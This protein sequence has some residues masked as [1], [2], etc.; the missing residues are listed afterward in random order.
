LLLARGG[1]KGAMDT[2]VL[3]QLGRDPRALAAVSGLMGVFALVPGMPF[4][5]FMAGAVGLGYLAMRIRHAPKDDTT[6]DPDTDE[7]PAPRSMGDTLDLD[8]MHVEFAA[9][10]V[11][12]VLDPATGLEARI[13]N[14][15]THIAEKFG[16][17]M[18][19]I[20]LTDNAALEAGTYI[21]RI[22]GVEAGHGVLRP[23]MMLALLPDS[24]DD[25]P[26]GTDVEE[27]VYGAPARWIRNRDQEKA[28]LRGATTI[29]PTEVLATHLLEITKRN[30]QRLLTLKALRRIL[31]EMTLLSNEDRANA[32]RR[33]LDEL[34]PDRVPVDCLHAVLRL[35]LSERV[36]IRNM[37]I[38]LEAIAE[39]RSG[40]T[41]PETL[42]E[43]VRQRLGAQLVAELKRADGTVPLIQLASDWEEQFVAYQVDGDRGGYDIALPP[44]QFEKL[45]NGLAT[46]IT[47]TAERGINAAVITS[48]RRRRFITTLLSVKGL[49]NPVLSFE[50][51][52]YE[53]RPTL[54]GVVAA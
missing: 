30:F 24:Q 19:E 14:M 2:A 7:P 50:E 27:P 45:T 43:L 41:Q 46:Q 21:V 34:I 52:G 54:V 37:P 36:S 22:H 3:Q 35:L 25:L 51:L 26:S 32:N 23:D 47:E 18:P 49:T 4:V 38:I 42:C 1:T 39:S 44:D 16:F 13:T 33:L 9:D 17:I 29:A 10:L 28:A 40:T 15:R 48:A 53:A 6:A 5:P 12:M 8:D 11:G 20:R 31:D